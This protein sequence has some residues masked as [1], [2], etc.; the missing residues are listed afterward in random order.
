MITKGQMVMYVLSAKDAQEINRRRTSG[1][2]IGERIQRAVWPLGAQ[3]H[4]GNDVREGQTFPGIVVEDFPGSPEAQTDQA[5]NLQ[6]WLD[7]TDVFW[8]TS[9]HEDGGK[10]PAPGTFSRR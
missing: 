2:S 5:V 6:V 4:I 3:A 9:R 8:A 7:G 10:S 1:H